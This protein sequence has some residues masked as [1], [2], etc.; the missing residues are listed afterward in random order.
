SVYDASN[1]TGRAV[2][3]ED[4][5]DLSTTADDK[6]TRLW[7][8]DNTA[9]NILDLP[10]RSEAVSVDCSAAANRAT[11]VIADERTSYD[12]G[13]FGDAPTRGDA[14]RTERLSAHD[15]TKG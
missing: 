10:S 12:G 15:G 4:L 3:V 8:A 13:S 6:C 7:Y 9:E 14:T 11:D 2:R 1:G 5:G